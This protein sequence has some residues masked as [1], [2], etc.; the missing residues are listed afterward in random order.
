MPLRGGFRWDD[1]DLQADLDD[2]TDEWPRHRSA[3]LRA[4]GE[5]LVGGLERSIPTSSS[6]AK[7]TLRTVNTEGGNEAE[8]VAGGMAGVDYIEAILEGSRPHAPGSSDP[9]ENTS[10][11]RWARRNNYPGGFDSIYWSIYHYGT[12]GTD[13]VSE[14][15]ATTQSRADDIAER[16]LRKRGVFD[17]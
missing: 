3:I 17:E 9:S 10:L 11:A 16:V 12:E 13:F 8:V 5:D 2:L 1:D 7:Q 15:V 4:L 14:P 6:A